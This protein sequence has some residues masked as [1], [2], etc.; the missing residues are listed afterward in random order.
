MRGTPCSGS[1]INAQPFA[2]GFFLDAPVLRPNQSAAY[3]IRLLRQP[4]DQLYILAMH[5]GDVFEQISEPTI[6]ALLGIGLIG[7]LGF[8]LRRHQN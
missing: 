6:V 8:G 1:D 5:N 3:G 7:L 2:I 4:E